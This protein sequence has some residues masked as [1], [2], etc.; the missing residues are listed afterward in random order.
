MGAIGGLLVMLA[1]GCAKRSPYGNFVVSAPL[2]AE[3]LAKDA[4][5]AMVSFYPP[6]LTRLRIAEPSEDAFGIALVE[7]L[8]RRGYAVESEHGADD[9]PSKVLRYVVDSAG[10]DAFYHVTLLVDGQT[11]ARPYRL[12]RGALAPAG[13]WIHKE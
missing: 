13:L 2:D 6:A 4:A 10:D 11:L 9:E 3:L 1:V 5:G 7:G 8:R 12:E